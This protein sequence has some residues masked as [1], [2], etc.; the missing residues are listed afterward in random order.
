MRSAVVEVVRGQSLAELRAARDRVQ[1]AEMVELRLDGVADLDVAG[2]LAGRTKP[3]IATC[4]AAWE[5]GQ[6][7]GSET[8]RLRILADA[9]R[10]GAEFVDV[11]WRADRSGLPGNDRTQIVLSHHDFGG[12]PP[13][14][15]DRVRAMQREP[16]AILK[17]AVGPVRLRDCL[18]LRDL[19]WN[20]R[21]HV[22][23]AMGGA[24]Q[25]T[26]LC[27]SRFGS[28]WTYGGT[29]APGQSLVADLIH[30]Y[31][32]PHQTS[33]TA[34]YAVGGAPLGHSASPAMHNPAF[35]ALGIDAVYVPLETADADEFLAVAGALGV[36]GASITAPL[37]ESLFARV[38]AADDLTRRIGALNTLR[39]RDDGTWDA[40]NFDPAGFFA[41]LAD[42]ADALAAARVVVLGAGGAARTVV[43]TLAGVGAAVEVA[44]RRRERAEALAGEFGVRATTWPPA[45]GWD[46]LVNTT[47][48][49][50][51]PAVGDAPLTR[52]QV[53]GRCVYDL[54]YN[55]PETQLLRWARD[56]G[57]EI[58]GGLAML[59]AQARLQFQW[60]TSR[61]APAETMEQGA[62][63]FLARAG[64][65]EHD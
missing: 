16:A 42:R 18:T 35:A 5:G 45:A 53:R 52:D 43:R 15:A 7:D 51:W 38:S 65:R 6:F 40:R 27:P 63:A 1:A 54:V 44:A 47:P 29:A 17:V 59:V 30:G 21:P 22:T 60:W 62:R 39:R 2:A 23:I 32:V 31:R 20:G 13:D 58:I 33:A 37:K 34:L 57:A 46:L 8:E 64:A 10:L 36:A 3:V 9:I 24:G 28:A 11:E 50:T 56:A 48:V 49:G 26:R 19:D 61:E 55:P 41:P 14:L 12:M 25:V 4:R